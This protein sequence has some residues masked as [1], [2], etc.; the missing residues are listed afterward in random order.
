MD[1]PRSLEHGEDYSGV[2]V[3]GGGECG[4][5]QHLLLTPQET[6]E[7]DDALDLLPRPP[8]HHPHLQEGQWSFTH[9]IL[10]IGAP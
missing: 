1:L 8:C 4:V 6:K 3:V 7:R 9:F 10:E 5:E 2:M